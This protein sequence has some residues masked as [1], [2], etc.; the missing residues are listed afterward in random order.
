[1]DMYTQKTKNYA[2]YTLFLL[3]QTNKDYFT[4]QILLS[5]SISKFK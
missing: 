3:I 1:M 4:V 5:T 2:L